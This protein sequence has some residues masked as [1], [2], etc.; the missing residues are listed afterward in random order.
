M[1]ELNYL[2]DKLFL[3]NL[4]KEHIKVFY[5]AIVILD[6]N[7]IPIREI[8]G[9]ATSG[10]I[11]LDGSSNVRRSGSLSLIADEYE[12]DLSDLNKLLFL[13]NRVQI[14]VGFENRIDSKYPD[15]IWFNQGIFVFNNPSIS[16]NLNSV[17]INLQFKDK[18]CL[19]NGDIGGKL[20]ASV[21]FDSYDQ[22]I[23]LLDLGEYETN[24]KEKLPID[25]NEYTVYKLTSDGSNKFMT[26]SQKEGWVEISADSAQKLIGSVINCKQTIYDIILTLVHVYGGEPI[27]KIIINDLPR[28]LK[29][30]VRYV[31]TNTLYYNIDTGEYS[32]N[33]DLASSKE[34]T[35]IP[36]GYNE[37]CG[38]QYTDFTFPGSLISS[39]GDNVA[40]V[41][42]KI[43]DVLGNFEFFYD[44]NGNFVFQE[45]KNYLNTSYNPVQTI[46]RDRQLTNQG[47]LISNIGGESNYYI[48]YCNHNANAYSFDED[49]S[50][51]SSYQNSPN[52]LNIKNDFHIWGKSDNLAIHYHLVI[53]EKPKT[54]TT[55]DNVVFETDKEGNYTGKLHMAGYGETGESYT[56]EDWRAEIYMQGLAKK[57]AYQRP[58]I[59]E[60]E[61]L[62][63]FDSIYDMQAK[64]WKADLANNPN[65]LK[66]WIDYLPPI[67][68]FK[69]I[70]VDNIGSKIYSYQ[71]DKI[72]K[73]Y[74]TDIPD[75]IMVNNGQ[76]A[77]SRALTI[78]KC[79]AEGQAY[80]NVTKE[81][82]SVL[83]IGTTG[84]TAQESARDALYQY[85]DYVE[86]ISIT[87]LPIYYLDAGMRIEVNDKESGINGDFMINRIN[88]PLDA[89]SNMTISATRA[90]QRI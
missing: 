55:W 30:I 41:L 61:I 56:P 44:L 70:S 82:A 3:Q 80:S 11:S 47:F 8:I 81:I 46:K 62:D 22:I 31:G 49:S 53:K 23:G 27:S 18:M 71:T 2:N 67:G 58:D 21:T 90:L 57:Q 65:E 88:L 64:K 85:T 17:T 7:D 13:N 16:H 6:K 1:Q 59:Y 4:D 77:V 24:P 83:A 68:D 12:N 50:L 78:A 35:W 40:G 45:K 89:K 26:W 39:I 84:Y 9:R 87:S 54:F 29:S 15:I 37:D 52:Y 43:T 66:Y 63:L 34:G 51:V 72:N 14:K 73:L 60:Q 75:K 20:P 5:T 79:S 42:K 10:N 38:Y 86:Q 33:V 74:N 19:L 48:D 36:F 25:P 69:D 32:L 76:T 28:Q